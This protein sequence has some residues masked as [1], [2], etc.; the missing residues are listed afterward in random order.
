MVVKIYRESGEVGQLNL[1]A[2][3]DEAKIVTS[4]IHQVIVA[5]AANTR[6]AHGHT[7]TRA[8]V[9]GGGR[10]P[11]RQKGTGRARASSTRSPLW[12]GGGISFGP[13]SDQ[14]FSKSVNRTMR[15]RAFAM[16]LAAKARSG[17]IESVETWQSVKSKAKDFA[18]RLQMMGLPG[19][20][21]LVVMDKLQPELILAARN[22]AS[23]EL[24]TARA[25]SLRSLL[26]ADRVVVD[27]AGL[28]SLLVRGGYPPTIVSSSAGK[29]SVNRPV[30]RSSASRKTQTAV[31]EHV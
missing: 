15:R 6:V 11:W 21:V 26:N 7:K 23:L 29:A 19:R 18:R 13:K 10:K 27:Q 31:K 1:P 16:A 8:E 2:E 25:V 30:R 17:A 22:F 4:L 12:P 20:R 3:L 9:R 28:D 5:E 24:A 14:N